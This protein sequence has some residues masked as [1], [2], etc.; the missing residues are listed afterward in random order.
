[1]S[2]LIAEGKIKQ[3]PVI[4][5]ADVGGTLEAIKGS[6]EKIAND[7][8]KVKVVHSAVGGITESDIVL[9]SASEGCIILGFNVRPT[10]AVKA[11]A[12]LMV[13]ILKLTQLFMIYL[14]M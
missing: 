2:G 6:L 3:L 4:I 1:M 9:A 11:K 5:K 7:E 8:V 13:L 14:M 12:K 10:G